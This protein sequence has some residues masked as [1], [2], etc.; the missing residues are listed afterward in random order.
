[1][2]N[3][4]WDLNV[5]ITDTGKALYKGVDATKLNDYTQTAILKRIGISKG[6]KADVAE[7]PKA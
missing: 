4:L 2:F 6:D 7:A 1:M 5:L 3:Q